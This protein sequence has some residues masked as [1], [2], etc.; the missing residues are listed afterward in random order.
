MKLLDEHLIRTS[1]FRDPSGIEI[2]SP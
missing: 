2:E 1:L